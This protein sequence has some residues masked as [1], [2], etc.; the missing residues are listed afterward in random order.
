[1]TK[2]MMNK[3]FDPNDWQGK[4]QEQVEFSEMVSWWC[5]IGFVITIILLS[6]LS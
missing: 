2:M 1:M 4:R 6:A 3:D 5:V